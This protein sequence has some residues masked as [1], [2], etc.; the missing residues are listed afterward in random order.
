MKKFVIE[1]SGDGEATIRLPEGVTKK[2]DADRLA[3]LTLALAKTLGT[4]KERH[5]AGVDH[6]HGEGTHIHA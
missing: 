2:V 1:F 4:V 6:H 3:D 5:I